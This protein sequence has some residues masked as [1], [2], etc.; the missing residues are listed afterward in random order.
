MGINVRLLKADSKN[1]YLK[2]HK[3]TFRRSLKFSR[4]VLENVFEEQM[5]SIKT[6]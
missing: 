2:L 3:I 1:D 6:I 4:T 5:N